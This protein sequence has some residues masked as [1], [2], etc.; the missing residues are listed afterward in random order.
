MEMRRVVI[1]GLGTVNPLGNNVPDFWSAAC[2]GQSGVGPI[3]QF[4]AGPFRTRIGA[5]VK[6]FHPDQLF[7]ARQA[8]RLDRYSQFALAA[9]IEA[10][11]NSGLDMTSNEPQRTA[12][13]IGTGIGGMGVFEDESKKLQ[14]LGPAR[15]SPFFVPRIMPNAAAAA[16]SIH[17]GLTG[18]CLSVSSACASAA[19]AIM[20]A[21]DLIRTGRSDV[22]ITGG[23]EAPIT[24]LGL[25]GFCAARSLSERNDAPE[26]ASRPFDRDREG[27]VLGEGAA[28]LVLEDYQRARRRGATIYCEIVGCAQT[29]DAHHMTAPDPNGTYAA[30][31]MQLAMIDARILPSEVHYLNAHATSTELGDN[32]EAN[33]IRSAFGSHVHQL[34]VSCTKSLL[35]HLCGASGGIAAAVIAL[36]IQKGI[37][38]PTINCDHPTEDWLG[39]IVRRSMT[40]ARVQTALLNSFGFGGHNSS[41]VLSAV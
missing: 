9:A 35:G 10:V 14:Q 6:N 27:F 2:Q 20:T 37:I 36:T 5:E 7:G 18:P 40:E 32:A 1:T 4:D 28:V 23:A 21:R 17:F 19:D 34:S 29:A 26:Q 33:A 31:A 22:V 24:P 13:V 16:I 30:Q 25:A 3:S 12:V 8:K 11:S 15:I 39:Q 41:I 38:H